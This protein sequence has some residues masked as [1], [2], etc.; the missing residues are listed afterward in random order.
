MSDSGLRLCIEG[1]DAPAIEAKL[2][3]LIEDVYGEAPG[4]VGAPSK[5]GP[6]GELERVDAATVVGCALAV[7]ALPGAVN[8]AID[9]A[10]RAKVKEKWDR[11]VSAV[12]QLRAGHTALRI[13]VGR[14]GGP[15]IQI[16]RVKLSDI[17]EEH[18]A[19]QEDTR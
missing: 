13:T 4:R 5:P 19:D 11:F 1:P 10:E 12:G 16:E 15:F 3:A 2:A 17:I 9:L 8:N 18:Q 7:L 6:N 14:K